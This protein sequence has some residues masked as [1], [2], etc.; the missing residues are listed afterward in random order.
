M[1][2]VRERE[3]GYMLESEPSNPM[4]RCPRDAPPSHS[5]R[6]LTDSQPYTCLG[7]PQIHALLTHAT[8]GIC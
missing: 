4:H 2:W 3:S 6:N 1:G 7:H 5:G 8:V